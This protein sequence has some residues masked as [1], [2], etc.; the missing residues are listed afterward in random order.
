MFIAKHIQQTSV[1][2]YFHV[3][4]FLA[5]LRIVIVQI[6]LNPTQNPIIITDE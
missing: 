2:N 3:Q 5:N 6:L 4:A 1:M